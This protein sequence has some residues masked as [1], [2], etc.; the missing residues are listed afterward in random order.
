MKPSM[1]AIGADGQDGMVPEAVHET[2]N[3]RPCSAA[4]S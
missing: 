4:V 1:R 2:G 3:G